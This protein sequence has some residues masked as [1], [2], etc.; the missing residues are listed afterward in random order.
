MVTFRPKSFPRDIHI[1]YL[2]SHMHVRGRA[3]RME[4][5][6]PEKA[7]E[8]LISIPDF[9]FS[10]HTGAEFVPEKP[11]FV[12]KDAGLRVVCEFDNSPENPANPDPDKEIKFGQTFDRNEMCKMNFGYTDAE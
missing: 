11:I 4:L 2:L 7:P 10:W 3:L 8:V 1:Q 6:K 12:P 5:L 9:D